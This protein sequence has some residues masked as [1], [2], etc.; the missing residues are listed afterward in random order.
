MILL[1][2]ESNDIRQDADVSQNT[3]MSLYTHVYSSIYIRFSCF[4]IDF[5]HTLCIFNCQPLVKTIFL[6][7]KP[8]RVF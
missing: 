1:S 2:G 5:G 8:F 7:Y 3:S 4:V 6:K